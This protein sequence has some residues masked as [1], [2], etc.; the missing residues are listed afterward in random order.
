MNRRYALRQDD[1]AREFWLLLYVPFEGDFTLDAYSLGIAFV[2][3]ARRHSSVRSI[4]SGCA[5]AS[6]YSLE[7]LVYVVVLLEGFGTQCQ[8]AGL[9]PAASADDEEVVGRRFALVVRFISVK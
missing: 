4:H 6:V 7:R 3:I 8:F 5:V 1:R 2:F 9:W